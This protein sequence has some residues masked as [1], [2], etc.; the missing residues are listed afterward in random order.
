MRDI[1]DRCG[2]S[3]ATVSRALTG[4]GSVAPETR[5]RIE[6]VVKELQYH[7]NILAR[8]L[9]ESRLSILGFLCC[10]ITNQFYAELARGAYDEATKHGFQVVLLN[11]DDVPEQEEM[12]ISMLQQ[13][14]VAGV[15]A[16]SALLDY[17]AG[18]DSMLQRRTPCVL[19]NR[20]LYDVAVDY[21]IVDN[22]AGAV[23]AVEHLINLGHRR[24]GYIGGPENTSNGQERLE[25]YQTALKK[26]GI[27]MDWSLVIRT[28]YRKNEAYQAALKLMERSDR[29]TAL[30]VQNDHLSISVL[31]AVMDRGLR[32]P[33]DVAM[34]S[35]DGTAIAA[36]RAFGLTTVSQRI[37]EMGK[38]AVD[39]LMEQ[40]SDEDNKKRY[41]VIFEPELIIRRTCGSSIAESTHVAE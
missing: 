20:R 12:C 2:V 38:T 17:S 35:F 16:A 10:D 31:D 19:V 13:L 28:R 41:Q 8:G 33:Q 29:P 7:P 22:V 32:V 40:L 15:I 14:N 36:S 21:V 37:Y 24:I 18:I 5:A 6:S 3:V 25:G 30:F 23:M 34:V 39:I 4:K 26:H 27:K 11:T 1:A 9:A